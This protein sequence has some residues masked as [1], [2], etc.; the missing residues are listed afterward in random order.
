MDI[1]QN[2]IAY[3][4]LINSITSIVLGLFILRTNVKSEIAKS[5]TVFCFAVAYWAQNYFFW[6]TASSD[7]MALFFI[8]NAM[9]GAMVIPSS[10]VYFTYHFLS[11]QNKKI[12]AINASLIL[13]FIL[14]SFS[15]SYI[16]TVEP[17]GFFTHW[18]VPGLLFH[19][20]L[21]HF[22]FNAVYAHYLLWRGIQINRGIKKTQISYVYWGTLIGF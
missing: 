2:I 18:P 14:F 7:V 10:Y 6:L 1:R 5:F 22:A 3:T 8:R 20:M 11:I 15:P 17:R 21:A 12:T 4:G 13:A 16:K 19:A 9:I